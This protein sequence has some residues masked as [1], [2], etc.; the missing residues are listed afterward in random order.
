MTMTE[1]INN[2]YSYAKYNN[3]KVI[4]MA[5]NKYLNATKL[6]LENNKQYK[7]WMRNDKS[8][9]LIDKANDVLKTENSK[10][11]ATIL[12]NAGR[13]ATNN[14]ISG[15]YVHELI[16]PH[17]IEWINKERNEQPERLIVDKLNKTLKGKIEVVVSCG[18][19]DILT[20]TEIIEVKEG[21]NWKSALGQI[22][23]YGHFY[24]NKKKRVHLFDVK[25]ENIEL[26][27]TIYNNNGVE[28]TYE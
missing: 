3:H 6:C 2:L 9:E 15:T 23:V 25:N 8:Q 20:D 16:I 19:I 7:D 28:L 26:I 1:A 11:E 4:I 14:L 24:L 12:V 13:G 10:Y 21:R 22:I 18:R 5:E 17:I 27:R